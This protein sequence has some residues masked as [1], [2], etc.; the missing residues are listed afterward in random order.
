[1][2]SSSVGNQSRPRGERPLTAPQI[3]FSVPSPGLPHSRAFMEDTVFE[4]DNKP[5]SIL[6]SI[7]ASPIPSSRSHTLTTVRSRS[8]RSSTIQIQDISHMEIPAVNQFLVC[9]QIRSAKR[10]SHGHERKNLEIKEV[11]D[12]QSVLPQPRPTPIQVASE[13]DY[14]NTSFEHGHKN[15]AIRHMCLSLYVRFHHLSDNDISRFLIASRFRGKSAY[16]KLW[17]SRII[18]FPSRFQ[19]SIMEF[20]NS[21]LRATIARMGGR[22]IWLRSSIGQRM[23]VYESL[24]RQD[25]LSIT[26]AALGNTACAVPLAD[27]FSD[28]TTIHLKWQVFHKTVFCWAC[29]NV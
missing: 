23:L 13:G 17:R 19:N 6:E 25:R 3:G 5:R 15:N 22:D 18:K 16:K 2:A 14:F 12:T 21:G 26:I 4:Q 10:K 28:T 24:W 11:W 7:E 9:A 27:I 1:M 29:E 8:P 20:Y